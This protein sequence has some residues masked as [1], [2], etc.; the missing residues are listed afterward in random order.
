MRHKSIAVN[1]RDFIKWAMLAVA[2]S[3]VSIQPSCET[4]DEEGPVAAASTSDPTTTDIHS[5]DSN[6]TNESADPN[7]PSPAP[8]PPPEDTPSP[9]PTYSDRSGSIDANHGHTVTLSASQQEAGSAVTLTLTSGDDGHT[10]TVDFS[11]G[12]V[13]TIAGGGS[14][15]STSS[16]DVFHDHGV[17]FS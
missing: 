5:A 4:G 10:H 9:T 8:T 6:D 16:Y 7:Q 12:Q 13:Q 2:G 1:R 3:S 14:A 15:G 11:S 17:T